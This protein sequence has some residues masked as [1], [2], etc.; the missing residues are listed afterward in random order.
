MTHTLE[1]P[2]PLRETSAGPGSPDSAT[3]E[4]SGLRTDHPDATVVPRVGEINTPWAPAALRIALALVLVWSGALQV[5]LVRRQAA[6]AAGEVLHGAHHPAANTAGAAGDVQGPPRCSPLSTRTAP[7]PAWRASADRAPC[8]R[9]RCRGGRRAGTPG[10]RARA[11]WGDGPWRPAAV[12]PSWSR[13]PRMTGVPHS[14]SGA[15]RTPGAGRAENCGPRTEAARDN[16]AGR[17][18]GLDRAGSAC[19]AST[20]DPAWTTDRGRLLPA[21][22]RGARARLRTQPVQLAAAGAPAD[23]R[24]LPAPPHPHVQLRQQEDDADI[25]WPGGGGGSR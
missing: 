25:S 7:G 5:R 6:R 10:S 11:R 23:P 19:P 9:R 16:R 18:L 15:T 2:V 21:H 3:A 17:P 13:T 1:Q 4:P 22:P 20:A 24:G 14:P 12:A 8:S